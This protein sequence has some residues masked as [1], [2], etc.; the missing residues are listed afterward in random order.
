MTE[1]RTLL[2]IGAGLA[3]LAA[4]RAAK[5]AGW[6]VTV[7]EARN[8]PGGRVSTEDGVD[9]G[10]HWIH[11]TE[12]NPITNLA[13]ELSVPTLFVGGDSSY[14]GGWEQLQLRMA[15]RALTPEEKQESIILIDEVRDAIDGVRREI[16]LKGGSDISL[17]Q[18]VE[19]VLGER[20]LSPE[21]RTHVAW[22]VALLSRDDWAAGA[23]NLSLLWWD[24]GY[25]VYGYGDSVFVEG[26]S[27][28]IQRLAEDVDVR[29]GQVVRRVEHRPDGVKVFAQEEVFEAQTVI[30]TLPL[31]V[32]KAGSVDFDP[33][34]PERKQKAIR[35][36]G[37]GALTKV[38]LWFDSPFWPQN[39]YVFG[40]MARDIQDAPT[41]IIN[42]W[43]T[44]RQ[45]VLVMLIGGERG[46]VIERRPPEK[47]EEWA[48]GV[49]RDLFGPEVQAPRRIEVTRWDSDP[50][51]RGSYAYIAVG[52]TPEDIEA[53]A[54]PV[55]DRLLFAGEA[56]V[57]T[58]WA[59]LH[60][61]YVSGLRE[62]A[63]LTGDASIL[64]SRHFTENRR[65]R[66]M[67][68]RANRFFNL[69]G[70]SLDPLEVKARVDVLAR[71]SVFGSV[72]ASDL[73]VLAM[74]FERR[75]LSDGEI[76]CR[77]GDPADCVFA[78]AGGII[79]V[80]LPG[81]AT[82]AA[83]RRVGDVVGEYGMFLAARRSATLRARGPTSVLTLRYSHFR[84]FML[85]FPES[86]LAL[87]E[88][89]VSRLH[90]RQT[91]DRG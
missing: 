88:L 44:H 16:E 67:L 59:C 39:Q 91:S 45:P 27:A 28:L 6:R 42:V 60:S 82:P 68:Q 90:A 72:P 38:V 4:A 46:R 54:A 1:P 15:G 65:W 34:L 78:V 11:G 56:T 63:R 35:R 26:A 87:F 25:E 69:V 50:F 86:M 51:A 52:A 41:S 37:M 20:G 76:L 53:L 24:D 3:G 71:G 75:D 10:A 5:G 7:L 81:A 77:A 47:V 79:D 61:A 89:C 55:G 80:L 29:L 62:A 49:L 58:H 85:A 12:G 64:P 13:R 2:V 32:L 40:H 36:L 14:T 73:K 19:R 83:E 70:R 33:P 31:G 17:E 84:R 9:M 43:K 48:C 74:M 30:V 22:H 18:A 21:M 57:R 66:E 8:R 23:S